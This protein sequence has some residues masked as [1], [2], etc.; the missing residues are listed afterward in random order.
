M[1]G[2]PGEASAGPRR[3]LIRG[4]H[5]LTQDP[6][7]GELPRADLL[8][9]GDAI[10][11]IAPTL[12]VADCEQIDAAGSIA[13]PGFVDAHRHV[14]QTQLRTLAADWTLFE[15]TAR[16]RMIYASLYRPEDAHLGNL[17][18]ALEAL[19]A[20]IT[21]L[22]DHAHIVNSP[23]HADAALDGLEQAG[24]GGVFCYGLYA[25]PRHHPFR[26]EL[27]P[28]WRLADARRLRRSRLAADDGLLRMGLAPV[29]VEYAPFEEVEREL[30]FARELGAWR[31]SCHVG[32]GKYDRGTRIVAR[33]GEAGL[34][35][36]DLLLVHGS[37][38]GDDELAMIADAGAGIAATPET[39]LQMGMGHPVAARALARGARAALGIDIVSDYRGDMF[40]QMRLLLQAQRAREHDAAPGPPRRLRLRTRDVLELATIGGARALG[41]DGRIGSLAPGKQADLILIATDAIHMVPASD[42]AAA[43][44][45][46]A[47]PSDVRTVL[48]AGRVVKRDGRLVGVDWPRLAERLR[49][50]SERIQAGFATVPREQIEAGV[51]AVML[52]PGAGAPETA[53]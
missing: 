14:W 49:A 17:C 5:V 4:A 27:D 13:L 42:A 44:V 8:V 37:A 39:E 12:D 24:I 23:E 10:R 1:A 20:G 21:T 28:G 16:M 6:A 35:A 34:L 26:L 19:D 7:L 31:I 25:N 38:L 36:E 41:L 51:A 45:L 22:A 47:Q 52:G 29:E 40:S 53:A 33:L 48:V 46:H 3:L 43:V 2:T 11:A 9:E 32:M 18:G 50:S 15:Y 30:R